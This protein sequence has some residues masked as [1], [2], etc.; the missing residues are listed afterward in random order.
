[1]LTLHWM[2]LLTLN[3]MDHLY[4]PIYYCLFT[5]ISNLNSKLYYIHY[6]DVLYPDIINQ[7][8]NV[9]VYTMNAIVN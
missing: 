2:F 3:S 5:M 7:F 8:N 9:H 4:I 6:F 1:M